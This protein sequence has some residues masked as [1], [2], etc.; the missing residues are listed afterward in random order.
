MRKFIENKFSVKLI[1]DTDEPIKG[2]ASI[3][4]NKSKLLL[5]EYINRIGMEG[6]IKANGRDAVPSPYLNGM[7]DKFLNGEFAPAF[8]TSRGC[9]FLCTFCD[10]GIDESKIAAFSTPRVAEEII[11]VAEKLS[12]FKKGVK[13]MSFFDSNWG[14]YQ[15]DIELADLIAKV[16]EKYDFPF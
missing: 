4:K 10:Q 1:R 3:S 2:C 15:K 13:T 16:M 8:E 5:G 14:L 7:L 6:S 11:Y 12:K 9:P